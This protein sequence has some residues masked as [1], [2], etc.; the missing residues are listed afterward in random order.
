MCCNTCVHSSVVI[1]KFSSFAILCNITLVRQMCHCVYIRYTVERLVNCEH[2]EILLYFTDSYTVC[3]VVLYVHAVTNK[4]L[5]LII[6]NWA[7]NVLN[8]CIGTGRI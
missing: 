1:I 2:G 7:L 4:M 3:K 5:L 8:V 6:L